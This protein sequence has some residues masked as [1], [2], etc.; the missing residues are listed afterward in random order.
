MTYLNKMHHG[1]GAT[2]QKAYPGYRFAS[3]TNIQVAA[4]EW[5]ANSTMA[6]AMYGPL[7]NWDVS[8]VTSM[9]RLFD[10]WP[11][12][13]ENIA[14][15]NV[16]SVTTMFEMFKSA[17]AFNQNVA[18]WNTISLTSIRSIFRSATRFNQD[19]SAWNVVRVKSFSSEF[20]RT[21]LSNSTKACIFCGWGSTF[22]T[23]YP[24]LNGTC[25]SKLLP[26]FDIR[27]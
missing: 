26:G 20:D 10:S 27:C 2:F 15:W 16:A 5:K 18:S 24:E 11:T 17:T 4:S 14:G 8:A 6:A 7:S 1:W 19:I 3:D 13:N 25:R 9:Y 23:T 22:R 12:F 21:L